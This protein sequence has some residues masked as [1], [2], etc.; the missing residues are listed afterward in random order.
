[1]NR[2][3][4]PLL[5]LALLVAVAACAPRSSGRG[6][7]GGDDDDSAT[8]NDDD[9][10]N[11]DDTGDDDDDTGDDDDSVE[12]ETG[13]WDASLGE[14]LAD[15]CFGTAG[16]SGGSLGTTQVA[17]IGAAGVDFTM[18]DSD[19]QFFE[20]QFT[21]GASFTC[22]AEPLDIPVDGWEVQITRN[23]NRVGVFS[24]PTQGS[25][26]QDYAD[27][28]LG[29]DCSN[30]ADALEIAFPCVSTFTAVIEF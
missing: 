10:A 19:Q 7:G 5:L 20:C 12:F 26:E 15:S 23:A 14:V 17:S 24:S 27:T 22:V 16:D 1:M 30:L 8:A 9:V 4:L 3:S 18:R 11:D 6:G 21:S 28:C 2:I 13:T 29:P 25:Y